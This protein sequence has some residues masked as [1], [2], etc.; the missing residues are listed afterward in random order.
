MVERRYLSA[1]ETRRDEHD[2]VWDELWIFGVDLFLVCVTHNDSLEI[3]R[4]KKLDVK[5]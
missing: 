1:W 5:R 4:K 3:R 2:V